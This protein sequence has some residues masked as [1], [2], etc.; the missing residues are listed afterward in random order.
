MSAT[1]A[2]TTAPQSRRTAVS[3]S[4]RCF[5]RRACD[6]ASGSFGGRLLRRPG[7]AAG[8]AP[9]RRRDGHRPSRPAARNPHRRL[10]SGVLRGCRGACRWRGACR[11]ARRAR[12]RHRLDHFRNG[13]TRRS[14][15]DIHAAVGPCIAQ[16]SYEV[17]EAFRERFLEHDH[18]NGASSAR[19]RQAALRSGGL[20][21]PPAAAGGIGEVEGLDLDTY[22][23][24]DR[25]YSYRRA[26][27]RGEEDYGRQLS[28]IAFR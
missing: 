27:H 22:A 14:A 10:C 19:A 17:D 12:G 25:F 11:L 21:R 4:P 7:M 24:A 1:A 15:G 23:H 13:A 26:T 6:G 18:A 3:R 8:G 28:A 5:R 2:T 9:A 20:R 16:P